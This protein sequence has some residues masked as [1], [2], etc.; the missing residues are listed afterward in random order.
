[1]MMVLVSKQHEVSTKY[2]MQAT[3]HFSLICQSEEDIIIQKCRASRF[4]CRASGFSSH[5]PSR[6]SCGNN[7]EAWSDQFLRAKH[8]YM[9]HN[10]GCNEIRF[11]LDCTKCDDPHPHSVPQISS[12]SAYITQFKMSNTHR[13]SFPGVSNT[14]VKFYFT[15]TF[16]IMRVII[17]PRETKHSWFSLPPLEFH[18]CFFSSHCAAW[19]NVYCIRM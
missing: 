12:L 18:C 11:K 19:Y 9:Q 7:F 15:Q 1:M 5:L 3:P 2:K 8:E 4:R 10:W 13:I 16:Y 17:S 6:T 14:H